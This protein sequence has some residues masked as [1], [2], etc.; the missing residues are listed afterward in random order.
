MHGQ[1]ATDGAG[2]GLG[3]AWATLE[4]VATLGSICR[5]ATHMFVLLKKK[6]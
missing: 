3:L 2:G 5:P 1:P 6:K 4:S